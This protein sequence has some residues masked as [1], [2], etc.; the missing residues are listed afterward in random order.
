[1][2]TTNYLVRTIGQAWA[3]AV[4]DWVA[5][6]VD[7][8]ATFAIQMNNVSPVRQ[9]QTTTTIG[10]VSTI[11]IYNIAEVEQFTGMAVTEYLKSD[12]MRTMPKALQPLYGA[13][14]TL[15]EWRNVMVPFRRAT[16]CGAMAITAKSLRQETQD[17]SP[18]NYDIYSDFWVCVKNGLVGVDSTLLV[19]YQ[20]D[21]TW[22][23][24]GDIPTSDGLCGGSQ[25]VLINTQNIVESIDQLSFSDV[26]VSFNN[27]ATVY[28]VRGRL[29]GGD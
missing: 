4:S 16:M 15:N 3:S 18:I 5:Y 21:W 13:R 10:G 17:C 19:L 22:N 9:V 6:V 24:P 26:D 25:G 2:P 20:G 12:G 27:G 11:K 7:V 1:M 28:S 14:N 8:N 23:L 29:S